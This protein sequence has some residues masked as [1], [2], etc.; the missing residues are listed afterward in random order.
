MLKFIKKKL[1]KP[2]REIIVNV[3]RLE[4]RAAVMEGGRLE[5]YVIEHPDRER[6]VGSI[7]KG[8]IQN[9]EHDLQ[10]AFVDI[11]QPKN[12]FLHYW[13]IVP[14]ANDSSIEVVR[15]NTKDPNKKKKKIV[16][17][18]YFDGKR[19]RTLYEDHWSVK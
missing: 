19:S 18:Y 3:E 10:A 7:F 6:I 17:G 12:A 9:L 14:A 5:E 15:R 1:S 4:I 16:T 2:Q 13:D 8:R 11:G